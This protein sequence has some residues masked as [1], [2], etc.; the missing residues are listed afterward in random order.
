MTREEVRAC[1][2]T[3]G[4]FPGIRVDSAEQALY[5]AKTIY[6]AGIPVAEITMT[7]PGAINVIAELAQKYPDMVVGAGTVLDMETAERCLDAG[8]RFLT[9]TGLVFEVIGS[10]LKRGI[11][12]I[13]GALTPTEV[14]GAWKAGADYVKIYPTGAMG[15]ELYV[16]SLK[17]PLPQ[18]KLI[19]AGGVNQQNASN[20]IL[21]GATA[22]GVGSELLPR[23]AVR[24]RQDHRIHEL[25]RRFLGFVDEARENA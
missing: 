20:Y 21:A 25:A 19:A 1:I 9:S 4:I 18:I 15:G 22:L 11:V 7:V 3:I 16:R 12:V 17:L 23:D 14:I 13:P 24:R 8:A 10:A 5:C 6:D 2:E